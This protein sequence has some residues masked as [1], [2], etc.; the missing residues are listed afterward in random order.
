MNGELAQLI[1]LASHGSRCLASGK[2]LSESPT[3]FQYVRAV[4]FDAPRR[5]RL[6]AVEPSTDPNAWL[7]QLARSG[8][9]RVGLDAI[10]QL[11]RSDPGPLPDHAAV[12]LVGG[13]GASLVAVGKRRAERWMAQ[14]TVS[15]GEQPP[16]NR[17]WYVHYVGQVDDRGAALEH[18]TLDTAMSLLTK[19]IEAA[20]TKSLYRAVMSAVDAVANNVE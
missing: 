3:V 1:W 7:T 20:V 2:P 12:A 14:W 19:S 13:H 6:R 10:G 9:D 18:P 4:R 16:D 15:E 8:I 17:I 11:D 5:R